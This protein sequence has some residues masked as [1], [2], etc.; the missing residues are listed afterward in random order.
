[1]ILHVLFLWPTSVRFCPRLSQTRSKPR[2]EVGVRSISSATTGATADTKCLLRL[3][4]R[5]GGAVCYTG[6]LRRVDTSATLP[7]RSCITTV[8][9]TPAAV[10][11]LRFS[12]GCKLTVDQKAV[13]D[14]ESPW[15]VNRRTTFEIVCFVVPWQR[16]TT[17]HDPPPVGNVTTGAG[18]IRRLERGSW[19]SLGLDQRCKSPICY[20]RSGVVP[21]YADCH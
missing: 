21:N 11:S 18:L 5:I 12:R 20:P 3:G 15:Q 1:M 17:K 6:V 7:A 19:D 9:L 2:T 4:Y 8:S 16:V 14:I 10:G 13:A